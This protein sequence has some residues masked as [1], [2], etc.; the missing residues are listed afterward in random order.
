MEGDGLRSVRNLFHL[1]LYQQ[2][3]KEAQ[4][5]KSN[6]QLGPQ[7]EVYLNRSLLALTPEAVFKSIPQNAPTALQAVK[8][9]ATYLTASEESKEL[10]VN[11]LQEWLAH[12][13]LKNDETL[14]IISAQIYF[15]EKNYKEALRLA[16]Q[17]SANPESPNL[18]KLALSVQVYLRID[19]PD[20][21]AKQV[22][23]MQDADDDDSLTQLCTAWSNMSQGTEKISEASFL[24]LELIEKFGPSPKLLNSVAACQICMKNYTQAFQYLKQARELAKQSQ[25]PVSPETFINSIVCLQHLRKP[26]IADK[27]SAELQ[28][29]AANHAW[30]SKQA[31]MSAL[32][33]KHAKTYSAKASASDK[34]A[35]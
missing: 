5:L 14:Q 27:I 31:E 6:K 25:E 21:A 22:K 17:P 10:V 8:Q 11:K 1:G 19:R 7:A 28:S 13:M 34:K 4:Q 33:D 26:D 30:L 2:A 20:L 32:F 16:L 3:I 15:D 12:D 24:L 9:L 29:V 18:E 35:V 23:A